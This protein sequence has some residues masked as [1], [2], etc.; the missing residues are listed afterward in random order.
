MHEVVSMHNRLFNAYCGLKPEDNN[1]LP[2]ANRSTLPDRDY[3]MEENRSSPSASDD[4]SED[5]NNL[6]SDG[7]HLLQDSDEKP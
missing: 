4:L 1:P 5:D 6:V 3:L 2:S 7:G